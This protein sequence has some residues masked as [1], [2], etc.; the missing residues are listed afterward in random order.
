MSLE[1]VTV[2]HPRKAPSEAETQREEL[3]RRVASSA[4]FEKSPRLRAFFLHVCR[5]ANED[6]SEE[7]TEQQI[8]IFVFGRQ[9]SYNPND[10]NIVRSQA[11]QLRMKLEHHFV[12]EGKD[13]PVVITIPKGQYLPVFETRL[14]EP[15]AQPMVLVPIELKPHRLKYVLIGAAVMLGL[16][17]VWLAHQWIEAKRATPPTYDNATASVSPP[18]QTEAAPQTKSQPVVLANQAGDIRIAAG[19]TGISFSDAGGN[20]WDADRFFDGGTTRPGP[21]QFFPPVADQGLFRSI[22][23]AASG[24]QMVPQSER[25]FR[26]NIPLH[27]GVYELKLYFADPL[28]L[29]AGEKGD[30]AENERHFH[31]EANGHPLLTD[32]DPIEDAGNAAIDV[33]VF[34]DIRPSA[35]GKLHLSFSSDWGQPAFVSAIEITPGISGKLGPIRISARPSDF[36]AADGT[37]WSGDKYFISGRTHLFD[38][39][40]AHSRVPDIYSGERHGNFSYSIP[41]V[42]GSYSVRLYFME[43]FFS[44]MVRLANCHGVG[45]RVFD[46]TCNG[47]MLLK[48]FDIFQAAGGAFRPVVR[49]FHGLHPN[50]QG[51]LLLSFSPK[52]NYG[53]IRAIEV[54]DETN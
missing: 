7:A 24:D 25:E 45:C 17:F 50:G 44:P 18:A 52:V 33:R 15:Q 10:D 12:N 47:V 22:R 11:R 9:P 36:V 1:V 2:M 6:K 49:E 40:A 43:S 31:V 42:P 51:K 37:R 30:D 14:K 26:Y 27:P 29:Q 3:V 8:G 4:T 16:G 28:R 46:V 35:D 19:R 48:D 34:K 13:E 23:E 5:C 38:N 39:P 21:L 41:V 54:I 53:E 20:R 32:F